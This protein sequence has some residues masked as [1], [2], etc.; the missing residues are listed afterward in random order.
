MESILLLGSIEAVFLAALL[1]T[2]KGRSLSDNVLVGFFILYAFNILL[3]YGEA[4]NQAHGFPYP[5]LVNVSPPLLFLHGPALWLFITTQTQQN[6]K[7]KAKQLLHTL[8]F[9]LVLAYFSLEIFFAA[10][11]QKVA[12]AVNETYQKQLMFP[13]IIVGLTI[14]NLGYFSWGLIILKRYNQKIK[15][16][17]SRVDTIDL[18]WLRFL[19][20]GALI[21]YGIIHSLYILN[22]IAHYTSFKVLHLISFGLGSVYIFIL[23]FYGLKQ[24]NIFVN[25]PPAATPKPIKLDQPDLLPPTTTEERFVFL[26]LGYMKEKKPYTEAELT[27]AKLSDDLKVSVDY[28]S[29]ILNRQLNKNFFDFIN[30][31]R[32]E[33]FKIECRNP[34]N[35][36]L[37][38]M[39]IAFNCGFNSKATFN[40]V[41]KQAT[42][43]TPSEYRQEV[44]VS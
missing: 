19:L 8:P 31:Y 14:S 27:I 13:V 21:C 18:R 9:I 3:S 25:A 33:E 41:F 16:Y 5:H 34:K 28:L 44:S 32:I 29:S 1:L 38:L 30:H 39:G 42:G 24:G 12:F 22:T 2:K 4:Y 7:F 6:F 35:A 23:G 26:L 36:K 20:V 15:D 40:R 11:S 37:T 17:F 10:P 43:Q